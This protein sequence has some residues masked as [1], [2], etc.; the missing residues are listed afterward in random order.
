MTQMLDPIPQK[1]NQRPSQPRQQRADQPLNADAELF[2]EVVERNERTRA[3]IR[4]SEKRERRP[5]DY[6][7][8]IARNILGIS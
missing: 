6:V 5:F 3:V 8:W 1:A 4:K 2:R 7:R